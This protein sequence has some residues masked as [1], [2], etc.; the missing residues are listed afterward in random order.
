[1]Q[2]MKKQVKVKPNAKTQQLVTEPDGSLT[3]YLKSSPVDGKA[4]KELIQVL[5]EFFD[6]S[7]SDIIIKQGLSSRMKLIEIHN[8]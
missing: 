7:K 1:M 5:A 2:T 8:R 4:N 3:A 6:V